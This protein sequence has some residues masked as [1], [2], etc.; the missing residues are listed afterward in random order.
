MDKLK[1][2]IDEAQVVIKE[3]RQDTIYKFVIEVEKFLV[4]HSIPVDYYYK[5]KDF[6]TYNAYPITNFI[7]VGNAYNAEVRPLIDENANCKPFIYNFIHNAYYKRFE[8]FKMFNIFFPN[9]NQNFSFE[10]F[11][12]PARLNKSLNMVYVHPKYMLEEALH[13]ACLIQNV[14]KL[15][16]IRNNINNIIADWQRISGDDTVIPDINLNEW[17]L[18]NNFDPT[19][20]NLLSVLSTL[21]AP[22]IRC[23]YDRQLPIII[24]N[25]VGLSLI[26]S[27]I[28]GI[29]TNYE[30]KDSTSKSFFDN[31][32]INVIFRVNGKQIVKVFPLLDYEIVTINDDA[33]SNVKSASMKHR[34]NRDQMNR[35]DIIF[36]CHT[37]IAL[38][39]AFN[40]YITYDIVGNKEVAKVKLMLFAHLYKKYGV[41][42]LNIT[43][44]NSIGIYYPFEMYIKELQ[45]KSIK[46]NQS[47]RQHN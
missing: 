9:Y 31:R 18:F 41:L 4:N 17:K 34:I 46:H 13:Q 14:G 2:L 45:V 35:T 47:R 7:D 19:Q 11:V 23:F 21:N 12:A 26:E 39:L 38:R 15:D 43:E 16:D 6:Y 33:I 40:E 36:D 5:E 1:A 42:D 44:S 3:S 10:T 25:R 27:S 8:L 29:T 28:K 20:V 32:I 37:N 22:I 24:T 30:R